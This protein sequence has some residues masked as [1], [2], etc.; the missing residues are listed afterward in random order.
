MGNQAIWVSRRKKKEPLYYA[1][2]AW[3]IEDTFA[4]IMKALH[5][6]VSICYL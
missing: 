4:I 6:S 1:M 3:G 5:C 2:P